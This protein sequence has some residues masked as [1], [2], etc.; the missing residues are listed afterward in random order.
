MLSSADTELCGGYIT[1][2]DRRRSVRHVGQVPIDKRTFSLHTTTYTLPQPS[3]LQFSMSMT[4]SSSS[5]SR[6]GSSACSSIATGASSQ[7]PNGMPPQPPQPPTTLDEYLQRTGAGDGAS[8][9]SS[10]AANSQARDRDSRRDGDI[11]DPVRTEAASV[12]P[13]APT[14]DFRHLDGHTNMEGTPAWKA[15]QSLNPWETDQRDLMM[16]KLD[17]VGDS[18]PQ[19]QSLTLTFLK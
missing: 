17:A 12:V 3:V 18:N 10:W 7:A 13:G 4:S 1:P 14:L 15:A 9:P 11:G 19:S 6:D 16:Q 2:W 5:K 8:L